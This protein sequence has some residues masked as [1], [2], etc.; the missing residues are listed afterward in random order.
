MTAKEVSLQLGTEAGSL[1]TY[2][3]AAQALR[4]VFWLL[5]KSAEATVTHCSQKQPQ[6]I[7]PMMD[8]GPQLCIE[9]AVAT[10]YFRFLQRNL[11]PGPQIM[12]P[13]V[14]LITSAKLML[15]QTGADGCGRWHI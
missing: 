2:P 5:C 6:T 4:C 10:L 13:L 3:H 1:C 9:L 7:Q 12:I 11:N 14:L 15:P 8:K